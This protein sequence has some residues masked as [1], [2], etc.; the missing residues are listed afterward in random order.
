LHH[1]IT[2]LNTIEMARHRLAAAALDP[3]RKKSTTP[4]R[5]MLVATIN[6]CQATDG[7]SLWDFP[8]NATLASTNK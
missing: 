1:A 3:S 4:R 6:E 5:F 2:D 7:L 8:D